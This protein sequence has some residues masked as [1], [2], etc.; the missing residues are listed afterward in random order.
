MQQQVTENDSHVHQK[1]HHSFQTSKCNTIVLM[2]MHS[3]LAVTC[4]L[5]GASHQQVL[6]YDYGKHAGNENNWINC[7]VRHG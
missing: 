7:T 5:L 2:E 3:I 4:T 6:I 1:H